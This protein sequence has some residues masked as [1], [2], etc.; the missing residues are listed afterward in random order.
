Y[1][2]DAV[3]GGMLG[4]VGQRMLT[5]ASKKMAAEF[6]GAID[7]VLTGAEPAPA[8]TAAADGAAVAGVETTGPE[9]SRARPTVYTAPPR[10]GRDRDEFVKGI[11]VGAGLVLLGVLAGAVATR[12]RGG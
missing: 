2:A 5:S 7:D 8:V 1:E 6:F 9:E 4:G 12:R 11:T 10:P 3:V